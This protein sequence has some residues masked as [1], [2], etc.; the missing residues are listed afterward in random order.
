MN[1]SCHWD[2]KENYPVLQ[3][4]F[5]SDS[6][7]QLFVKMFMQQEILGLAERHWT[8]TTILGELLF[9]HLQNWTHVQA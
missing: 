4:L 5:Q 2:E 6:F 8:W 3:F 9:F 7:L 1:W